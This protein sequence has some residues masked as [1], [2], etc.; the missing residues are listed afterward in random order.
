MENLMDMELSDDVFAYGGRGSPR[1]GTPTFHEA[2]LSTTLNPRTVTG[3]SLIFGDVSSVSFS[4]TPSQFPSSSSSS[5]S[6]TGSSSSTSSSVSSSFFNGSSSPMVTADSLLG[7]GQSL[8][9]AQ[10]RERSAPPSAFN[11]LNY[12]RP[13]SSSLDSGTSEGGL[14]SLCAQLSSAQGHLVQRANTFDGAS[15]QLPA[16]G[17]GVG[18]LSATATTAPTTAPVI[19]SSEFCASVGSQSQPC[20]PSVPADVLFSQTCS[21]DDFWTEVT[22]SSS[23]HRPRVPSPRVPLKGSL[24]SRAAPSGISAGANTAGT[25]TSTSTGNVTNSGSPLDIPNTTVTI[26]PAPSDVRQTPGA[27]FGALGLDLSLAPPP[28]PIPSAL[29]N[30]SSSAPDLRAIDD[31]DQLDD[32][33]MDSDDDE[34]VLSCATRL[35]IHGAVTDGFYFPVA[36]GGGAGGGAD[37]GGGGGGQLSDGMRLSSLPA[38]P[39]AAAVCHSSSAP[40]SALTSDDHTP[41]AP[42][43]TTAR[44]PFSLSTVSQLDPA[45]SINFSSSA[46]CFASFDTQ[47]FGLSSASDW[48]SPFFTSDETPSTPVSGFSESMQLSSDGLFPRPR[49]RRLSTSFFDD[50]PT[51]SAFPQRRRSSVAGL[52]SLENYRDPHALRQSSSG[53]F[54]ST[55]ISPPHAKASRT[56]SRSHTHVVSA[57]SRSLS[58]KERDL[59]T[60]GEESTTVPPLPPIPGLV[61]IRNQKRLLW[62]DELHERFEQ[63]IDLLGERAVPTV[64]L[65]VMNIPDLTRDNVAS[66]LQ[67]YRQRRQAEAEAARAQQEN[68]S[69]SSSVGVAGAGSGNTSH[70]PTAATTAVLPPLLPTPNDL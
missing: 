6:S 53:A 19:S 33:S 39:F 66:H 27:C 3:G 13:H 25:N 2:D 52:P 16:F 1:A 23:R 59:H 9:N 55:A 20:L 70:S 56:R 11:H 68:T 57:R 40:S 63:A 60:S 43:T 7:A 65:H 69:T 44:A 30:D 45:G 8:T 37:D 62:T 32:L 14:S 22:S 54:S 36:D 35:P 58:A 49:Q 17:A 15:S 41:V 10:Q 12:R 50:V 28:A 48:N 47:G 34:D 18:L 64:I 61:L 67:K 26:V 24:S 42:N 38:H 51:R 4:P 21:F 46:P 31:M 29:L 5:S